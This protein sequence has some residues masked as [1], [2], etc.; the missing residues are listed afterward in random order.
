[1]LNG[2]TFKSGEILQRAFLL[3][4]R[5]NKAYS[6]RALA[7]DLGVSPVF[8]TKILTGK[9]TLPQPRVKRI[10]QILDMDI[11]QQSSFLKALALDTIS[12]EQLKR[13]SAPRV[14]ETDKMK[15][16][17]VEST[18]KFELLRDWFNMPILTYLTCHKLKSSA[19]E[20]AKYFDISV[21]QVQN[22]LLNLEKF[23]LI[24]KNADNTWK[25]IDAH[26]YFP[27]TTSKSEV[28][29]FHRQM[30]QKSYQELNKTAAEDF[31]KRLITGFSVAVNP[32]NL[33]TAKQMI[34]D[35]MAQLSHT[36]SDGTCS[37]VYQCNMQ[38]IPLKAV[39]KEKK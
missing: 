6:Q 33:E 5:K 27:T 8:V 17:Q 7:R 4:K 36:L 19:E 15:N 12:E 20:I 31:Q 38:M 23:G 9:K 3:K 16:Y 1:M 32:E 30:I 10:F 14:M 2:K 37:E 24:T 34:A 29:D 26:S 35:F 11:S 28:R 21:R 18:E 25:K 39:A 13:V 22:S